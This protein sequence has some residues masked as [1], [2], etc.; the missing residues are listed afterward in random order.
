ML[1]GGLGALAEPGTA[2]NAA[3]VDRFTLLHVASGAALSLLGVDFWWTLGLS[4][5]FEIVENI[6]QPLLPSLFPGTSPADSLVN[7]YC[8]TLAV[9]GGW[10]AT[11][12]VT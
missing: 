2:I 1:R 5:A 10:A 3:P 12:A 11:E 9:L 4:I 6:V 8:D 7:S